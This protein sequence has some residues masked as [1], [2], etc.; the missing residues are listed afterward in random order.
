LT[1]G[2][3]RRQLWLD[4]LIDR[5]SKKK[6]LDIEVRIALRMGLYQI[7]FLD[8]VPDYSA[9]NES[10]NLVEASGKR[11]AKGFVNAILRRAARGLPEQVESDRLSSISLATSHP[12]WLIEKWTRDFGAS[13]AS[14]IAEANNRIPPIAFRATAL[15]TDAFGMAAGNSASSGFVKGCFIRESVDAELLELASRN[16]LYFQDE[17]SQIAANAVDLRLASRVLD[18][19]AAPGSKTTLIANNALGQKSD[20]FIVAG[21]LHA[22]RVRI[23]KDNCE[24]QGVPFVRIVQYDAEYQ[25]PFA[26]QGFGSVLIDAPCSGT[27]TIRHNPEIRYRIKP[28]DLAELPKKQLAILKNASYL[29]ERGGSLLY[30]TCS[31]EREENEEVCEAFLNSA[32]GFRLVAPKV[33][34]RLLTAD[35]Y[36]RTFPSRD[37]MD[38]FFMAAFVRK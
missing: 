19:C 31:L 8:R 27:G 26:D 3:L 2:V 17:A 29:V 1:L 15:S 13:Q 35:G 24:D 14:V 34:N 32:D 30:S 10:V 33:D 6:T 21:D 20:L 38:G 16:E 12:K 25:L 4:D 28:E 23:L 11:S 22:A 7:G 37:N 9:I 5:L 36:A 18:V